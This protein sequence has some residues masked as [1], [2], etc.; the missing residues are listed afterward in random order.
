MV[1]INGGG[2]DGNVNGDGEKYPKSGGRKAFIGGCDR[3]DDRY[4]SGS[5]VV[6]AETRKRQ[7]ICKRLRATQ[8]YSFL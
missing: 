5:A 1:I 7:G 6:S 2:G 3:C 8:C 4:V